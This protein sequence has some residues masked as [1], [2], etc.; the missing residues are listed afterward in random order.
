MELK[1]IQFVDD[2]CFFGFKS[3]EALFVFDIDAKINELVLI[4]FYK[5]EEIDFIILE[6]NEY[7]YNKILINNVEVWVKNLNVMKDN[8]IFCYE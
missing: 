7:N 3:E 6:T 2:Y 5:D 1:R 8:F 4:D